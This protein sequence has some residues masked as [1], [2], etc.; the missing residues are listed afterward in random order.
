MLDEITQ[1]GHDFD[2][3][4]AA[5]GDARSLDDL[6]VRY[7]GRKGGIVPALFSK[8]KSVPPDQKRE[9]GD[10]LNK[11]RD[12][13]E[14]EL[15]EKSDAVNA[16][17]E[18][19]R[20]A[21]ETIDVTLP[22]RL[23]RLGHLHP[24]TIARLEIEQ[25]FREMAYTID[26]GPEIENDWNNFEALNFTPDHPARDTQDTFFVD[27][28]KLLLRTHTSNVQIRTMERFKP[29]IKVLSCGRVYRRD[30]ITMRRSP[31][32]HQAEG[33]LIDRGIHI[34]HLRA[35]LEH[36]VR[37]L[38]GPDSKMRMRPSFFPFTEPS[39][40]V[41][42]SC[43]FCKGSGCGTCSQTGWM[44]ILGCGMVH[45]QVLRNVGI[46][47]EEWS[48]FAFGLGIDRVAMLKFDVPNIRTLF[49]NDLRVL[50]Q[51]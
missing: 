40:E 8:L 47:P 23:P 39:A 26:P 35:T 50:Q 43:I 28:D 32:F 44:E 46:D 51:F 9:A 33:L 30:E 20:Q 48:G 22:S 15:K 7:F 37:R 11:L 38:F 27:V 6:R 2:A 41:D 24:T 45:P 4:L 5:A 16:A 31:M 14:S 10:A 19:R 29:P 49:E 42:M 36:I 13:L 34:G 17:E 21:R 25:L 18:A 12:R 3:A 1:A